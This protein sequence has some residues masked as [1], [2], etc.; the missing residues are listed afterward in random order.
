MLPAV[1]NNVSKS[2]SIKDSF[3][4]SHG[5]KLFNKMPKHIRDMTAVDIEQFKSILDQF[6]SNVPDEPQIIGYTKYRRTSSNS[7]L[8][9]VDLLYAELI[10]EDVEDGH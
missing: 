4:S 8:D 3:I 5:L 10:G 7:L 1:N 2:S 6:L 9:M